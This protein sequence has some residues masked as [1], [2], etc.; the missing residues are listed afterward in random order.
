MLKSLNLQCRF[1]FDMERTDKPAS[2]VHSCNLCS[3]LGT[4]IDRSHMSLHSDMEQSDICSGQS[5]TQPPALD[6][7]MMGGDWGRG[8]GEW[9]VWG[10]GER[11]ASG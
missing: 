11:K 2:G 10:S 9:N 6:G 3:L 1:H 5:H 8:E 7:I 4:D